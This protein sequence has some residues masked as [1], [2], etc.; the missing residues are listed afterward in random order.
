MD[1]VKRLEGVF[2]NGTTSNPCLSAAIIGDWRE[3]VIVRNEASTEL[4][5]YTTDIPTQHRVPCLMTDI[6]YRESVAAENVAYNQP[7][8]LGY[9]LGPDAPLPNTKKP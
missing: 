5:I 2:N 3:E 6:P 9:Y 8:E 1:V 7:P 4:R